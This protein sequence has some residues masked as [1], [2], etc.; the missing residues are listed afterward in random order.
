M[1]TQTFTAEIGESNVER[2]RDVGEFIA[3]TL[4][5]VARRYQA[6]QARAMAASALYEMSDREL[7]DIGITRGEIDQALK[8]RVVEATTVVANDTL[9]V[10]PAANQNRP[11]LVA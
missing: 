1:A 6:W 2:A 4:V 7:R 8:G 11:R 3:R 10:A 9:P 5:S